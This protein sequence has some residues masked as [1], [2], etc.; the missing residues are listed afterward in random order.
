MDHIDTFK[1]GND[2]EPQPTFN[3]IFVIKNEQ[4]AALARMEIH[5]E[6]AM[7]CRYSRQEQI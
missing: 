4:N 2:L 1:Q 3:G 5:R 7:L 6:K